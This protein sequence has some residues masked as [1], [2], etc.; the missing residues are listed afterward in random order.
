MERLRPSPSPSLPGLRFRLWNRRQGTPIFR[1][2]CLTRV[3][4]Q[5]CRTS[6][7]GAGA[8]LATPLPSRPW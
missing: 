3:A 6:F 2:R 4:M 8:R 5:P 1:S 7:A